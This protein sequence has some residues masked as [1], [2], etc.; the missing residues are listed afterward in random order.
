M[1]KSVLVQQQ[2]GFEPD[3][4]DEFKTWP[5]PML[6][7]GSRI[8]EE[9]LLYRSSQQAVNEISNALANDGI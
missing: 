5:R 9:D 6:Q 2:F 3:K 8:T 1:L 4:R 7:D